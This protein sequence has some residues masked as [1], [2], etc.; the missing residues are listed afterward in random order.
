MSAPSIQEIQWDLDPL[1]NPKSI[2]IVGASETSFFSSLLM[3]NL[4]HFGFDGAIY[5]INPKYKEVAGLTCYPSL[6]D[7][8]AAPD[9]V[10]IIVRRDLVLKT[11]EDAIAAGARSATIVSAGF[12]ETDEPEWLHVEEQIRD[13][14]VKH[15]FPIM[16]PNCLGTISTHRNVGALTAPIRG[17]LHKGNIALVMQSGG[18]LQG[19]A[20]P[21]YQRG[22]GLSYAVSSGNN[23]S[24]DLSDFIDHFLDDPNTDVICAY[25]EGFKQPEKFKRVAQKALDLG[26]PIIVL[27]VGKSEKAAQ[28]TLAHTGSLAGSDSVINAVFE[29]YGVVRVADFDDLIETSAVFA[30][31]TDRIELPAGSGIGVLSGSGGSVSLCS[32]LSEEY[33]VNVPGLAPETKQKLIDALPP[34]AIVLNPVDATAQI[35]NDFEL[36]RTT[37]RTLSE[38]PNIGV[39]LYLMALGLAS[40]DVPRHQKLLEIVIDVAKTIDKPLVITSLMSHSLDDWQREFLSNHKEFA[41]TQGIGKSLKA[42]QSLIDY[43]A[44]YHRNIRRVAGPA[45]AN[46]TRR[47]KALAYLASVGRAV[48]TEHE[49]K[50]LLA[51]YGIDTSKEVRVGTEDEAVKA[52]EAI[53]YP[54]VMKVD[55]PD[56]LHKTDAGG[57]KV[58]VG[59]AED[60]RKAFRDINEN[61]RHYNA[62]ADILGVL[63]QEFISGGSETI[64]GV[65]SDPQFGP[66]VMFGMGGIFVEVFED[67]VFKVPPISAREARG[68]VESIKGYKILRGTRG[69]PALDIDAL[70]T[71]LQAIGAMVDELSDV[72][73]EMD[74][75][76]LIVLP[77]GKGVKAAD[78]LLVVRRSD[79]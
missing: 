3:Q 23:M 48:L 51:I 75:N 8:P 32:D 63:V 10:A 21:F 33:G 1:L 49:T 68:M 26:K 47:E 17:G 54:V 38:D 15:G 12:G 29:K 61:A 6:A 30:S 11:V 34:S 55:S 14:S 35:L 18:L 77:E 20:M 36:Y 78:G 46:A 56:I 53:G 37:M 72:I 41:Y 19:L 58:G 27:K 39:V 52:A 25:V 16:G 64:V 28:A 9:N 44:A 76:P 13:L 74:I 67:S 79:G 60:V 69:K 2:A 73:E 43:N 22:I 66:S 71:A 24:L 50:K 4:R 5:P 42:I 59:N 65:T 7:I 57:V 31:S 70:I 62:D 45:P 40:N